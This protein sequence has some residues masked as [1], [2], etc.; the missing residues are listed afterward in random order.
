MMRNYKCNDRDVSPKPGATSV[1]TSGR[2]PEKSTLGFIYIKASQ[3][4][5]ALSVNTAQ[6]TLLFQRGCG[7]AQARRKDGGVGKTRG[8]QNEARY[9]S[10]LY[11]DQDRNLKAKNV[12]LFALSVRTSNSTSRTQLSAD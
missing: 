7:P 5:S 6:Y 4:Y 12:C 3:K 8:T 2:S 10:T 11:F 9:S 1:E